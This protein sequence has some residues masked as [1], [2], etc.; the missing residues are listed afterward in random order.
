M[1]SQES[2]EDQP[3]IEEGGEASEVLGEAWLHN[4]LEG[5]FVDEQTIRKLYA[6]LVARRVA[7]HRFTPVRMVQADLNLDYHQMN[8]AY[9]I[10]RHALSVGMDL[11][12]DQK[13]PVFRWELTV[14]SSRRTLCF[15]KHIAQQS[16]ADG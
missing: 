5:F 10:L 11:D 12:G 9:N 6:Y 16:D 1:S 7:G 2:P 3:T 15:L 13:D 8:E 4:S 14:T